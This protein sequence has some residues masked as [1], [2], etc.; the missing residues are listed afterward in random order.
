MDSPTPPKGN[1]LTEKWTRQSLAKN[2]PLEVS[3]LILFI[4]CR[5]KNLSAGRHL[6][7]LHVHQQL[8]PCHLMRRCTEPE[9]S[10][11]YL[12]TRLLHPDHWWARWEAEV[13]ISP[14]ASPL[15]LALRPAGLW[16]LNTTPKHS[17]SHYQEKK[18]TEDNLQMRCQLS[19][20]TWADVLPI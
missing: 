10:L 18:P 6:F 7:A 3:S 11:L 15:P 1:E 13:Q 17:F 16:E 4:T 20:E 19:H 8:V 12:W 2:P 9:V 14:P 5:E